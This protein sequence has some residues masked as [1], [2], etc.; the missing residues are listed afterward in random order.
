MASL[1]MARAKLL[2]NQVKREK[3]TLEDVPEAYQELV[4]ELLE[5]RSEAEE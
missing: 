5:G 1:S 2:A 4:R 3:I